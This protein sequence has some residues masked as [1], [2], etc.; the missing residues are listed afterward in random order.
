MDTGSNISIIHPDLL[1]GK[2]QIL[3]PVDSCLKTVTGE[4]TPIRGKAELK[5]EIGCQTFPHEIWVAD[6][7][8]E[9]ILGLDF[10]ALHECLVNLREDV[11]YIGDEE[12][13]L[14]KSRSSPDSHCYKTVLVKSVSIPPRTEM[15]VSARIEGLVGNER[16]GLVEPVAT[17]RRQEPLLVGRTLVDLQHSEVPVRLM[18]LAS[19]E[20]SGDSKV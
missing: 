3:Q 4:K 20:R 6:I 8:D 14:V 18:N 9:C 2:S 15:V 19:Q 13:P 1:K 12:V 16:W 17:L 11:L 5:I 7:Q 10:L